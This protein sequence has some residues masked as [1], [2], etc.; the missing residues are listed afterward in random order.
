MNN[1]GRG[2]GRSSLLDSTEGWTTLTYLAEGIRISRSYLFFF[3]TLSP[4]GAPQG[5]PGGGPFFSIHLYHTLFHSY[6]YTFREWFL[7]GL[8][9][10]CKPISDYYRRFDSV[11]SHL[12]IQFLFLFSFF[13][14]FFLYS[15]SPA[16]STGAG[17]GKGL[18]WFDIYIIIIIFFS[19]L[20]VIRFIN[21]SPRPAQEAGR[22]RG[23]REWIKYLS[24][25]ED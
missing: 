7:F 12:S 18:F 20:N 13:I 4:P 5:P 11:R 17:Q 14:I 23:T 22:G 2:R 1:P 10:G 9:V 15:F 16:L 6:L 19:Y 8:E 21:F 24:A 3:F 25:A